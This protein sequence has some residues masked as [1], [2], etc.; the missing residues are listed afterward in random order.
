[1][2]DTNKK[3]LYDELKKFS[4]CQDDLNIQNGDCNDSTV[5]GDK[6]DTKFDNTFETQYNN[7]ITKKLSLIKDRFNLLE[8]SK[9]DDNFELK[10]QLLNQKSKTQKYKNQL[11]SDNYNYFKNKNNKKHYFIITILHIIILLFVFLGIFKVIEPS[12]V[13][14]IIVIF[15]IIIA[16]IVYFKV[17]RDEIRS[18]TTY[19]T[20]NPKDPEKDVCKL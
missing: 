5:F 16:S 13:S 3:N 20:F 19:T 12:I 1:M 2:G 11:K 9:K 18:K 17:K 15:Y 8:K 10:N 4:D 7:N 14:L 6:I